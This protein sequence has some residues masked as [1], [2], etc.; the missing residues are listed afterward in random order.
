MLPKIR[1]RVAGCL[2][3]AAVFACFPATARADAGI[4]MLPVTHQTMLFFLLLV[5]FIEVIYLQSRLKTR[6]R[7]TLVA[8]A[9]VNTA[10][11][12]LGFPIAFGLYSILNS[13]AGFPGGMR[14]VFGH[15][16]FV[17]LWVT[18]K[19]IPD[20]TDIHGMNYV[21]L[22]VFV[23]LLVPSYLFTR[24][25]KAWVF[26]W[27]DFLRYEGDIKPAVLAA[28]RVSYFMIALIGCMLL[29]RD[30]RNF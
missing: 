7:R 13:W 2:A 27:Y 21:L 24:I 22:G 23:V 4:P 14:D 9:T 8:V 25:L 16:Q 20:P 19:L 12:G 17:P 6:F 26:E 15:M 5:I 3:A 18:Q 30:F 29:F 1:R 28:N 10:T 11:T